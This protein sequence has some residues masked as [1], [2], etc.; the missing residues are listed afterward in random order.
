MQNFF[1]G[2]CGLNKQMLCFFRV[3]LLAG[4]LQR[5]ERISNKKTRSRPSI[6][7]K[8]MTSALSSDLSL[9]SGLKIFLKRAARRPRNSKDNFYALQH[10]RKVIVF[11][12]DFVIKD[13]EF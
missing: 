13:N 11:G 4:I 2:N 8:W 12:V 3:F 10:F 9:L 5:H 6:V 1:V 7:V